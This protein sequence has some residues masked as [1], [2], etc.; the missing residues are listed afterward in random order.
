MRCESV[1]DRFTAPDRFRI[2]ASVFP[3]TAEVRLPEFPCG[4][5]SLQIL[6]R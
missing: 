1:W 3:K 5:R 6:L 4:L 2:R